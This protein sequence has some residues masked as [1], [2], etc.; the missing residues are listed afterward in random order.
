LVLALAILTWP[1]P[2]AA[3]AAEVHCPDSVAVKQSLETTPDGWTA[4]HSEAVARLSGITFFD[5]PPE[6][7]ASL[8]YDSWVKRGGLAYGVW[9]FPAK[10]SRSIWLSCS[11]A[12]TN[13]VLSKPLAAGVT[14]CT[15]TYSRNVQ[16]AGMPEVKKI[17]CR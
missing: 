1:W 13:I 16:V 15:V 12:S 6:E 7:K 5:G 8:V 2:R 4:S 17:D 14:E 3:A 10:G 11:Y 9:R